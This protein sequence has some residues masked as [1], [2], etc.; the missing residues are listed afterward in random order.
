MN[1]ILL[2]TLLLTL[3]GCSSFNNKKLADCSV[4]DKMDNFS[5]SG[6]CRTIIKVLP[7]VSSNY[8]RYNYADSNDNTSPYFGQF[9]PLDAS[10]LKQLEQ[11]YT[12]SIKVIRESYKYINLEGAKILSKKFSPKNFKSMIVLLNFDHKKL[13]DEGYIL[14]LFDYGHKGKDR[15][16]NP[17]IKIKINDSVVQKAFNKL[18]DDAKIIR[19]KSRKKYGFVSNIPED[20]YTADKADLTF[21]F[22]VNRNGKQVDYIELINIKRVTKI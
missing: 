9:M 2:L 11:G 18:I 21:R 13:S 16:N 19:N 15:K 7:Y 8:F 20:F 17:Q 3:M 6:T 12:Y 14:Y 10:V 4:A 1:K 22:V 5:L